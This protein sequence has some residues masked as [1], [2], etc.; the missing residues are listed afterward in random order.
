MNTLFELKTDEEMRRDAVHDNELRIHEAII[1]RGPWILTSRQR[2]ILECLRGRQGRML[3]ITIAELTEKIGFGAREIKSDVRDL[4]VA[5]RLPI[6]ASRDGD[7]GGY[8]FAVTAEERISGTADYCKEII[9]LAERVRIVR[10]LPD[11][12]SLWGQLD[13]NPKPATSKESA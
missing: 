9:A 13:L 12:A 6:V 8:F 2:Q 5:F 7:A 3:A 1:G 11:L 4:V 10:N